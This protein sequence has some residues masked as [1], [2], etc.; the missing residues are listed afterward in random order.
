[1]KSS[2]GR[3]EGAEKMGFTLLTFMPM[4]K[5]F[6]VFREALL[7][8]EVFHLKPISSHFDFKPTFE[9]ITYKNQKLKCI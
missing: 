5:T 1:M 2:E 4:G 6:T 9:R 7:E 3:S 8:H